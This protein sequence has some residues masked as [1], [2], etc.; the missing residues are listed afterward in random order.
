M[1]YTDKVKEYFLNPKNVGEIKDADGIGEVGNAKCGDIMKMYLKI[2]DNIITNVKFET[3]GCGAAIATTSVM[4]EL[5]K[6][7]T[8]QEALKF[9]NKDVIDFLGGLP[10]IKIH[11]SCLAKEALDAALLDYQTKSGIDL[12]LKACNCESCSKHEHHDHN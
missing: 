2:S 1:E 5:I 6:G 4:T 3:Y 12:G 8:I 9:T 10:D 7:K 11:C